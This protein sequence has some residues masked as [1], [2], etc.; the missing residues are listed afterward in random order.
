MLA[1]QFFSE[2]PDDGTDILFDFPVISP[3]GG[4]AQ[5]ILFSIELLPNGQVELF[6]SIFGE[7]LTVTGEAFDVPLGRDSD[8]DLIGDS[9]TFGTGV[10]FDSLFLS[11]SSDAFG[12]SNV[13]GEPDN[14]I[15]ITSVSV[16]AGFGLPEPEPF[17]E[18]GSTLFLLFGLG[19][20]G[21]V[22]RR[23]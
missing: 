16:S 15:D 19:A 21:M 14:G 4:T 13:V 20:L 2:W 18:P 12:T 9:T 3:A 10:T 7:T 23:Q 8:G 6:E 1:V 17:P 5:T 22:R 11:V